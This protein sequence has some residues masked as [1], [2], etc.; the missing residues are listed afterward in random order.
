[1]KT[2]IILMLFTLCIF[3]KYVQCQE[4]AD[5]VFPIKGGE[6]YFEKLSIIDSLR[7]EEIFKRVK[8]WAINALY[9]QKRALET[10]DKEGGYI[11]YKIRYYVPFTYP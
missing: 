10:E 6:I 2:K 7:K 9:S 8:F 5:S 11:I 1:M 4:P 3:C